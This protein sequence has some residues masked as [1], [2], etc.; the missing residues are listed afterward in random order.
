MYEKLRTQGNLTYDK[1]MDIFIGEQIGVL[2]EAQY[3]EDGKYKY[4]EPFLSNEGDYFYAEQGSRENFL[5]YWLWNRFNYMDSKYETGDYIK[6]NNIIEMRLNEV[7]PE[8]WEP[9]GV[10][11]NFDFDITSFS[12]QYVKVRYGGNSGTTRGG[13]S[14]A[15]E[16]C[17]VVAPENSNPTDLETWIYGANR[18]S[19]LGD[20]SDKYLKRINVS[21]ATQLTELIIGNETEGYQNPVLEEFMAG[22]NK[23]LRKLNL[24]NCVKLTGIL[25]LASCQNLEELYAVGTN[26][27][28][29]ELSDG[30][31]L[32]VLRLPSTITSLTLKNKTQL[33]D[34]YCA[35]Y[36]RI[37]RITI[38]DSI[39]NPF[40][41]IPRCAN[42]K[43]VRLLNIDCQTSV[44]GV[45]QL[46]TLRGHD[47]NG[48]NVS[49]G[50]AVSGKITLAQSSQEIMENF[51]KQL[52]YVEFAIKEELS[53]YKVE[54]YDGDNNLLQTLSVVEG[55]EAIYTGPT[56]T[57]TSTA[58]YEYTWI[59]WDGW[60]GSIKPIQQDTKVY[61]KFQANVREYL[62]TF[63]DSNTEQLLSSGMY[64][65]GDMP[66]APTL[67]SNHNSWSPF[68]DYVVGPVNYRS[69]SVPYPDNVNEMF[70]FTY[71]TISGQQGYECVLKAGVE[72]PATFIVPFQYNG[73]R[74]LRYS[75]V[76]VDTYNIDLYT[77]TT[78]IYLP[79]GLLELGSYA[80]SGF[81][82]V[83]NISCPSSLHTLQGN[84]FSNN[85]GL[86]KVNLP[87]ITTLGSSVFTGCANLRYIILGSKETPFK[88]FNTSYTSGFFPLDHRIGAVFITTENGSLDDIGKNIN[89]KSH[90]AENK[91]RYSSQTF[92][93]IK[94]DSGVY[95]V[96]DNVATMV[97][98]NTSEDDYTFPTAIKNYPI[99][100]LGSCLY[101]STVK[102]ATIPEDIT[103][104]LGGTF[105][106]CSNLTTV[107]FARSCENIG[108]GTFYKCKFTEFEVPNHINIFGEYCFF[109]CSNLKK[110]T[111]RNIQNIPL[112]MFSNCSNI[113]YATLGSNSSPIVS[114]SISDLGY[115]P[116]AGCTSL[117]YVFLTTKNGN[118][119][120]IKFVG[121]SGTYG[122]EGKLSFSK[123]TWPE[124][125][126]TDQFS[127][128]IIDEY[129]V[130]LEDLI[131]D[132]ISVKEYIIPDEIENYPVKALAFNFKEYSQ[133]QTI[134]FSKYLVKL[135]AQVL[136]GL[137][138]LKSV[139]LP[140]YLEEIDA[141]CFANCRNLSEIT[142]PDTLTKIGAEAFYNCTKLSNINLPNK[143]KSLGGRCFFGCAMTQINLPD[144][145]EE[146]V[147]G[148][149][150][151]TS[152]TSITIPAK[153][154]KL[155]DY[156]AYGMFEGCL[157][158]TNIKI[159]GV[160]KELGKYTFVKR[161]SYSTS[162]IKNIQFGSSDY[163]YT[164]S[165][166]SEW[167]TFSANDYGDYS[168]FRDILNGEITIYTKS[169]DITEFS[170]Y[171][172]GGSSCSF[173]L[174]GE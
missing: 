67:P 105:G 138:S 39:T 12:D 84:A 19:S 129:V 140:E 76:Y 74:V 11:P 121:T 68:V 86:E 59:G 146:L 136:S 167:A 88:Q 96:A 148:C 155:P 116:F 141:D 55:G 143:I 69:I 100:Y 118:I 24:S 44:E 78:A 90:G 17:H 71:R 114:I 110:I 54:F 125:T 133:L 122:A 172:W 159:L 8:Y 174:K 62:I 161:Y 43:S 83:Q 109:E 66:I 73:Q 111:I 144:S 170:G 51:Q 57:K 147:G 77:N 80:L 35:D 4:L 171:D 127:Y 123:E 9:S 137:S 168:L 82:N 81:P 112:G 160:V 23:L 149:F 25:S 113:L 89:F 152:L 85:K 36:S 34:I 132:K 13:R 87:N 48:A 165:D 63:T 1:V 65:Y 164:P 75:G 64:K 154:T 126:N 58:Q 107:N 42:L 52:P 157:M 53:S 115:G 162:A 163:Y 45:N 158:L 56:P 37:Q 7:K 135:P 124:P 101:G 169:T 61:A 38:E 92:T 108:E 131:V 106:E 6:S 10:K 130:L 2:C 46:L 72:T 79:D 102:Q 150:A 30:G 99:K 97:I 139:I 91:V 16:V 18:I 14:N 40:I 119:Q 33:T 93:E 60:S 47:A 104:L 28:D 70:T 3:N 50:E 15:N 5:K 94:D 32:K 98:A 128:M 27:E 22:N 95:V 156:S 26:L 103:T 49:I 153:I 142:L 173:V 31:E 29:I 117:T 151:H 41:L 21:Y 134:T 166:T 20:L 120:D 145:L